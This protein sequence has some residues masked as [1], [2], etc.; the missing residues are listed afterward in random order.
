MRDSE[1]QGSK[2]QCERSEDGLMLSTLLPLDLTLSL[3]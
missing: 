1:E 3:F 2:K